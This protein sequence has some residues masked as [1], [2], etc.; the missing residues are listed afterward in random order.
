MRFRWILHHRLS[1]K[2]VDAEIWKKYN[3]TV[4]VMDDEPIHQL[5]MIEDHVKKGILLI[6][7]SDC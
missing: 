7:I 3:L 6:L 2:L 1:S 5:W 4:I